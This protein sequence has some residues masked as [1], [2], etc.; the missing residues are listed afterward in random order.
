MIQEFIKLLNRYEISNRFFEMITNNVSNNK[1][2]KNELN[3]VLNQREHIW[4][5]M[6][7]FIFCLAYIINLITQNFIAALKFEIIIDEIIFHLNNEQIQN[8]KNNT[9]FSD[10]I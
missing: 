3:K 7:N 1:I 10:L 2:L 5:R 6:S 4:N 9:S 8:I